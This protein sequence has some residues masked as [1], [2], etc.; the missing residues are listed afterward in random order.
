MKEAAEIVRARLNA[1]VGRSEA[2]LATARASREVRFDNPADPV[3]LMYDDGLIGMNL[4]SIRGISADGKPV[5][6]NIS[7]GRSSI[8]EADLLDWLD[9]TH[10]ENKAGTKVT[11]APRSQAKRARVRAAIEALWPNGRMPD[12]STLPNAL[13]CKKV[14]DWLKADCA[15]QGVPI[16]IPSDDTI[17]R[18]AGRK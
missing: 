14:G 4:R 5:T 10:P 16:A 3:L 6:H 15:A 9:R 1:S 17:L 7:R 12:Q 8:S 2:I 13:L 11:A 18:A